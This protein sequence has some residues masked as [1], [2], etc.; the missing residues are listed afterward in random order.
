VSDDF[1]QGIQKYF[2]PAAIRNPVL[3]LGNIRSESKF[4]LK[5]S[6]KSDIPYATLSSPLQSPPP[7]V[8]AFKEF[9]SLH[10]GASFQHISLQFS[11][12]YQCQLMCICIVTFIIQGASRET[13][14]FEI[15]ITPLIFSEEFS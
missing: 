1:K 14:V 10:K 9:L 11:P 7:Q 13:D 15:N 12:A 5:F 8:A 4:R 2:S 3:P 6:L